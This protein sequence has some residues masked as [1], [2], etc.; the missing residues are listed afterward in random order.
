M[1]CN[2]F[3]PQKELNRGKLIEINYVKH[4]IICYCIISE[5]YLKAF[6]IGLMSISC[7]LNDL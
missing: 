1:I 3:K 6:H 7:R 2:F 4:F 5:E